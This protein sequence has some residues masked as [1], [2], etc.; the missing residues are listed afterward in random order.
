MI[1]R[2]RYHASAPAT[3][4]PPRNAIASRCA[5]VTQRSPSSVS[6]FATT[7]APKVVSP[8]PSGDATARNGRSSF[9]GVN[10]NV[11]APLCS[12]AALSTASGGQRAEAELLAGKSSMPAAKGT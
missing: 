3:S 2:E 8:I 5:S 7:I 10:S 6:G 1:R 11:I 4:S 12:S 9:G